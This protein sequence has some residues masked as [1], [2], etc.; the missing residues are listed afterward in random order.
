[1]PMICSMSAQPIIADRAEF[2]DALSLLRRGHVLV[3][4]AR[5]SG[6]CLLDGGIV[7]HS[8]DPLT[9]YGLID[10]FENPDGFPH[11]SYYRLT[12]RGRSFADRACTA[13]QST[14]LWQRLAVRLVG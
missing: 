4:A 7:Y 12:D 3:R 8:W 1:M 14:P 5:G 6:P 13:W 2:I 10:E 11:A 9:R